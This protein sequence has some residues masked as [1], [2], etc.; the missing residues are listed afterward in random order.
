MRVEFDTGKSTPDKVYIETTRYELDRE[1]ERT[2]EGMNVATVTVRDTKTGKFG[3][4]H[5]AMYVDHRN[6]VFARVRA[7]GKTDTAKT[8]QLKVDLED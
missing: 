5:L 7:H 2:V 1:T 8:I 3:Y 6:R 4:L